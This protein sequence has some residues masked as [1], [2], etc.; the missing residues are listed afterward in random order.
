MLAA[1]DRVSQRRPR[2]TPHRP[3]RVA[4]SAADRPQAAQPVRMPV[5]AAFETIKPNR[6][7]QRLSVQEEPS[8]SRLKACRRPSHVPCSAMPRLACRRSWRRA[9]PIPIAVCAST[10][11]TPASS[12]TA[13]LMTVFPVTVRLVDERF[14]RYAASE[15]IRA[16]PPSEPRLV[17]YGADFPGVPADVRGT[18][19]S[20]PSSPRSARLEWAIAEALDEA[21]LPAGADRRAERQRRRGDSGTGAAAVAAPGDFALAGAVDLV[22]APGR[23]RAST[24]RHGAASRSASRSGAAATTSAS[25]G[26]TGAEFSFRYSLSARP[27]PRQG[28]LPAPSRM[29]RCS[30]LTARSSASLATASVTGVRFD[31]FHQIEGLPQ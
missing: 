26:S 6:R 22:G 25:H 23:R 9:P 4:A 11:T 10:G 30:T 8:C 15:F 12:L 29:N 3:R 31:D 20:C 5:L 13:T 7:R 1:L 16:N 27:R 14:F 21:S 2:P 19:G 18:R 17:R 28:R 24:A